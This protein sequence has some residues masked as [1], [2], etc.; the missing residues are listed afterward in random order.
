MAKI[1]CLGWGSLVWDPRG[2]PTKGE[3]R[4]D[5]PRV[6]VEFL[7]KSGGGRITLVLHHSA[8]PL[9]SL[10]AELNVPD[11]NSAVAALADREGTPER[12]IGLWTKGRSPKNI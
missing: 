10:W 7:R 8:A 1:A 5:G 2:L 11:A 6:R 12:N 9:V 3:W 4:D